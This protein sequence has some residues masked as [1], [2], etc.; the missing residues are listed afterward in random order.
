MVVVVSG[1]LDGDAEEILDGDA[2]ALGGL[3]EGN[4][5][6]EGLA[7]FGEPDGD[8]VGLK[9]GNNAVGAVDDWWFLHLSLHTEGQKKLMYTSLHRV[10]G[11]LE[12]Q[13]AQSFLGS[14]WNRKV[15]LSLHSA[16]SIIIGEEFG[17]ELGETEGVPDIILVV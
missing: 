8:A 2:N 12:A 16:L 3:D 4:D 15:E 13:I 1:P 5:D 6:A 9:V 14:F 7:L 17:D 10:S 11:R